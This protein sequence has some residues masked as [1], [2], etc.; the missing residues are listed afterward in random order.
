MLLSAMQFSIVDPQMTPIPVPWLATEMQF[1]TMLWRPSWMPPPLLVARTFSMSQAIWVGSV[2]M[3]WSPQSRMVPFRTVTFEMS[4]MSP[5]IPSTLPGPPTMEKP[6]RS[7]V[8][9]LAPMRMTCLPDSPARS[10][11]R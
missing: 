3:A 11:V 9:L 2:L 4:R 10:P 8:T 7:M 1:R 6:L 5:L